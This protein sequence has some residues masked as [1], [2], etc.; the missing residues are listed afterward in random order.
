MN[1]YKMEVMAN[2]FI[3]RVFYGETEERGLRQ[4][5]DFASGFQRKVSNI[6]LKVVIQMRPKQKNRWNYNGVPWE[7]YK[8]LTKKPLKPKEKNPP[9]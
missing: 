6:E 5:K 7:Y 3:I 4:C 1:V 2:G 9:E 8:T